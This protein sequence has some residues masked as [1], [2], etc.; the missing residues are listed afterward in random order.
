MYSTEMCSTGT[1]G[2]FVIL[3]TP[4]PHVVHVTNIKYVLQVRERRDG[5]NQRLLAGQEQLGHDLGR[6]GLR[7]D[8]QGRGEHVW[9]GHGCQLS[10]CLA[11]ILYTSQLIVPIMIRIYIGTMISH[12]KL[13]KMET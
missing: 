5:S 13:P 6:G 12:F 3:L 10:S 1:Y 11:S 4:A 7:Q 2:I 9:G 8:R